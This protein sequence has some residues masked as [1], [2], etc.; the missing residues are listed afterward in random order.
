MGGLGLSPKFVRQLVSSLSDQILGYNFGREC[1]KLPAFVVIR[2]WQVELNDMLMQNF[3]PRHFFLSEVY[4]GAIA[5]FGKGGVQNQALRCLCGMTRPPHDL[6]YLEGLNWMFRT[7][8]C[9]I[10]INNRVLPSSCR[11]FGVC[12]V[13]QQASKEQL[14]A[15]VARQVCAYVGM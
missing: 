13:V 9:R 1:V 6:F 5:F 3:L 12:F 2:Q 11:A 14:Q 15:A 10:K 8:W 7:L 4:A